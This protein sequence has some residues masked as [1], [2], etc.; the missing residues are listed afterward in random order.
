MLEVW[1]NSASLGSRP[2]SGTVE[3]LLTK[4]VN[5]RLSVALIVFLLPLLLAYHDQMATLSM[6]R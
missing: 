6:M 1:Q 5:W 4:V 3:A 2:I